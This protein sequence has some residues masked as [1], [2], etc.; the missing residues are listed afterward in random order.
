MNDSYKAS[1]IQKYLSGL[2]DPSDMHRVEKDA[3]N[4]PFL[5][6]AI[7]GLSSQ[8]QKGRPELS[9]LQRRLATRIAEQDQQKHAS[10][11]NFQRLAVASTAAVL[12]IAVGI[13]F[14]MRMQPQ[15][16]SRSNAAQ[17]QVEVNLI[18]TPLLT[19]LH[20][21]AAPATGWERYAESLS[22]PATENGDPVQLYIKIEN[23]IPV[24]V[25]IV[26]GEENVVAQ[27]IKNTILES[28]NWKGDS[29]LLELRF[30]R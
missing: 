22:I 12:L 8:E 5:Q 15:S 23:S 28:T 30:K 27:T 26:D 18:R 10:Y 25:R 6:D 9:I 14:W 4:D 21:N 19:P 16:H 7:D 13:L 20:G 2:L 24:S 17:K 29:V 11:F 3:L 1:I